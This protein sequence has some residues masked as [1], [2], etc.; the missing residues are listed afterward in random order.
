MWHLPLVGDFFLFAFFKVDLAALRARRLKQYGPVYR[1]WFFG[2]RAV[3]VHPPELV[4]KV[5][6]GE[7]TLVQ[8]TFSIRVPQSLHVCNGFDACA[9]CATCPM[10]VLHALMYVHPAL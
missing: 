7:G 4:N 8:C 1:I 6:G 10:S 3:V 2:Q 5:L 9:V